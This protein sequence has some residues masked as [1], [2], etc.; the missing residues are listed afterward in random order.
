[1][2]SFEYSV[3][4]KRGQALKG[5]MEA[6]GIREAALKLREEGYYI[7]SL[8]PRGEVKAGLKSQTNKM[9]QK[10]VTL[11]ELLI[12]T[13]QFGVMIRAGV[14][15]A[16]C[17]NLMTQ[18]TE[19]P[20]FASVIHQ[21]RRDVE[22]GDTL[23]GAM[24]KY[25]KIFPTIYIHMVEAGEAS[26]QLETVL[27]SLVD[28]LEREFELKKKVTG[29]MTYPA[30]IVVV[31]I[32]VVFIL[33]TAV[34]PQFLTIFT[35]AGMELPVLTR[36]LIATSDMFT[37]YWYIILLLLTGTVGGI[38]F[39]YNTPKGRQS[40]DRILYNLKIIG[41]VIQKLASARFSRTLATLLNSGIMIIPSLEMVERVVGN[42]IIASAI[43]EARL[44][45]TQGTGLAKP[46]IEKGVFPPMVTQ[47]ITVGEETG[48][49][50]RLLEQVADFY[51]KEAGYAIETLTSLIEPAII[52]VL[53]VVVAIIV[54]AIMI[55]MFE[56]SSGATIK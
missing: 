23:H 38:R 17:L 48:E 41:P 42:T 56:M 20:F 30:V 37:E 51:E 21:I 55:P 12:F 18:Q 29:A 32:A 5:Y 24:A 43:A 22:G 50:S 13:R 25:P 19:N 47:M 7:T 45:I 33:M 54:A 44:N 39:L 1:M 52:I 35:D 3:R 6:P 46:L 9:F 14:N 27:F 53:G 34:I 8:Q 15:L 4:D 10:K 49:L 31:A 11:R 28:H 2:P 40:I 26:G 36:V 16:S